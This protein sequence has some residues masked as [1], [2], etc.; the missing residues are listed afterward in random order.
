[1][2]RFSRRSLVT[3]VFCLFVLIS[4][5]GIVSWLL[6]RTYGPQ[7]ARHVETILSQELER[8]VGVDRVALHLW[9]IEIEGVRVASGPTWDDGTLLSVKRAGI[10]L[11]LSSLWRREIIL[12]RI[13]VEDFDLRLSGDQAP[14]AGPPVIIPHQLEL[15]PLLV[16][17]GGIHLKNGQLIYTEEAAKRALIVQGLSGTVRPRDG[18]THLELRADAVRLEQADTV[19]LLEHLQGDLLLHPDAAILNRVSFRWHRGD[20]RIAG[21]VL[22]A[23][24]KPE[25]ALTINANAPL[26]PLAVHFAVPWEL[27][28][29]AQTQA[30]I[31]GPL[32]NPRVVAD[33]QVSELI[34]GPSTLRSVSLKADWNMKTLR[35]SDIRARAFGG[36]VDAELTTTPADLATTRMSLRLKK[37]AL[38]E[39]APLIGAP[40]TPKGELSIEGEIYGDPRE[41][42]ELQGHFRLDATA[43]SLPG[44]LARLGTGSLSAEG[45][46]QK[47]TIEVRTLVTKWPAGAAKLDGEIE[48]AGRF[49]V[50]LDLSADAAQFGAITGLDTMAGHLRLV[51]RASGTVDEPRASGRLTA[52]DLSYAGIHADRLESSFQ[53]GDNQLE[54]ASVSLTRGK[55]HIRASALLNWPDTALPALNEL[56]RRVR[57]SLDVHPSPIAV[58]EITALLAPDHK[59][60]G[61]VTV[62]ARLAGTMGDWHGSG[63]AVASDLVVAEIPL[64]EVKAAFALDPKRVTFDDTQLRLYG[65]PVTVDAEWRWID[66][67]GKATV[68][69]HRVRLADIDAFPKAL[70]AAGWLKG[71]IEARLVRSA[72]M[73][74]G[75]VTVEQASV[76]GLQLGDGAFHLALKDDR[77]TT[78]LSFPQAKLS[79]KAAGAWRKNGR[80]TTHIQFEE[81]N[82]TPM[83]RP[84]L[85]EAIHLEE[86]R[87]WGMALIHLPFSDPAAAEGNLR[88][89]RLRLRIAGEAWENAGPAVFQL[90]NNEV[91]VRQAR[92]HSRLGSM[93]LAGSVQTNGT[94]NLN[95]AA[96]LPLAQLAA[97]RPEIDK[98]EG[99]LALNS[100]IAGSLNAPS[101]SGQGKVLQGTV[102]LRDFNE[103]F[104][105][106]E[107]EFAF[108]PRAFRLLKLSTQVAGGSIRARGEVSLREF[109]IGAYQ[110]LVDARSVP[111]EFAPGLNT[112]W[113][114]D[115]ELVG[116]AS[117]RQLRGEARLL[118]GSYTREI[119]PVTSLIMAGAADTSKLGVSLPLQVSL[120]LE[121]NLI[122]RNSMAR[123][124]IGGNLTLQGTLANPVLFGIARASEGQ[125]ILRNNRFALTSAT[126]RFTDPRQINPVLDVTG[127]ARIQSYDVTVHITGRTEDLTV[128]LSSVPPLPQEDILAL[129]TF[130][131]TRERF[132]AGV[133]ASEAAQLLV[134]DFL[135]LGTAAG[136][137][138]LDVLEF[139]TTGESLGMLRAGTRLT[140]R[141]LIVY[142]QD[143][144]GG[145][146]RKLRVEYQLFGPLLLAGEQDF[147][148]G[149]GGDLIL[150]LRF[151]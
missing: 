50:R 78:D 66:G 76:M 102:L 136:R 90:A 130:G 124:R 24:S 25:L 114:A 27:K 14:G 30:T 116:D 46:L 38:H 69:I 17:I 144:G 120:K 56:A 21:E 131:V 70:P 81:L 64:R 129:V 112:V 96:K 3:V 7:W 86:G 26:E 36:A 63:T 91:E 87:L 147:R 6:S 55:N 106:V 73:T 95:I 58:E 49:N 108:S 68:D 44:D 74:D 110:L 137:V 57:F 65:V 8:P 34:A 31:R 138:G 93:T 22:N 84:A 101:P 151:R 141:A 61:S 53:F 115:L 12:S 42:S 139:E 107:A 71:R 146:G 105:E 103:T 85:P 119:S 134:R 145:Q 126:A 11:A 16:Q 125:I 148:G 133:L 77:L 97:L 60:L 94:L 113:D 37:A 72:L 39:I 2:F 9:R 121:D 40:L 88:L 79:G 111:A 98:A 83:L 29:T 35:L 143:L 1:M 18:A 127:K 51:A 67:S 54:L 149:F 15:G 10:W 117:V 99:I 150:R 122:V 100:V 33:I 20:I 41:L 45:I 59:A 32:N 4:A 89:D 104:R 123:L 128:I 5:I 118:R 140:E 23:A 82:I 62:S 142:S 109:A 13:E 48:L 132:G 75:T 135:G 80:L 28:G 19:E 43:V 92:L 47:R 52:T